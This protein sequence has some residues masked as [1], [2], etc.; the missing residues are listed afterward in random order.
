MIIFSP[1]DQKNPF[2]ATILVNRELHADKSDRNCRHVEFD[3]EGSRIRYFLLYVFLKSYFSS[4]DAGDHLGVFPTNDS[5]LVEKL[6]NLLNADLDQVFKLINLDEES[7]KRHPFPCPTSFRTAL[8]HYVD[9]C[10]PVKSHVLK[11]I[12]EYASDEV[13]KQR[14]LLLS[15]ASEEG[16]VKFMLKNMHLIICCLERIQFVYT[17]GA[18]KHCRRFD[19]L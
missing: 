7:S 16:L 17:K 18:S 3:I 10:A 19:V 5:A 6:G 8:T 4:Y 9:I 2:L 11:A 12:S 15:T 1:F 13:H 14:L